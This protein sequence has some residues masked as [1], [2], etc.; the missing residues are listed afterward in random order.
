MEIWTNNDLY[1]IE[2]LAPEEAAL[3]NALAVSRE[4]NMPE[5]EV[6]AAQGKFLY[7]LAKM[8]NA[9]RILE[10]GTLGGY[11]TIW[12]ARALPDDGVSLVISLEYDKLYADVARSN[13]EHAGLSHKVEIIHGTAVDTMKKMIEDKAEPFDMIFIDADKPNNPNYLKL[14]LQL[15]KPGTVIFGDNVIRD[16]ELCNAASSDEKVI[17]VRK[18]IEDMGNSNLLE[19]TALQTVGIKGY[20]GFTISIVK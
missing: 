14:S 2:H 20:D 16:G 4:H 3:K 17:G 8:K 9:S 11:S 19:S 5:W 10:I 6:S 13:I 7:L 18:F 1:I 15:A 12:L